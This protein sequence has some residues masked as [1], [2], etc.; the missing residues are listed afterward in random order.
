MNTTAPKTE[1]TDGAISLL[2]DG[3][4]DTVFEYW[5]RHCDCSEEIRYSDIERTDNGDIEDSE[6]ERVLDDC[7]EAHA[8]NCESIDA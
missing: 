2:D 7:A 5:C 6:W 1:D 3:T 4:L 8:Q